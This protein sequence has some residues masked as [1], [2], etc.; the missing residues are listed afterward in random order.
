MSK[1]STQRWLLGREV[2]R[3]SEAECREVSEYIEV[4]RSLR[5][6]AALSDLFGEV[7][8][9]RRLTRADGEGRLRVISGAP[10]AVV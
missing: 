5:R 2:A 1:L 8:A 7:S 9:L 10:K 3:L 4:M 6:E